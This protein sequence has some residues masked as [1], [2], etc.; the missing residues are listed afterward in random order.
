LADAA[1]QRLFIADT[2]HN[3][4]VVADMQSGEVLNIVGAGEFGLRDGDFRSAAFAHPQGMALSED[5]QTLYVA[6]TENHALRRVDL[7]L[8]TVATLV[9]TGSQSSEYPP[10]GGQAPNVALNSPWDLALDG[11]QLYIAMAG[12]HQ[13]WV[14]DLS[15]GMLGPFAGNAREGTQDGPLAEAELAQPSGL[16]LD[17][18]G[19]LYFTDPEA[20]TVRWATTDPLNGQ[21]STLVGSGA[22]LFDFGDV[23][24]VGHEARLQ[25]ALGIV[26]YQGALYVV[27][28]YNSKIKRV[29]PQTQEIRTMLGG[30]HGWRDGKDPLFY[31]PGGIDAAD[32][33]LYV[34]DTNNHAVRVIDLA[35]QETNTL[36]LKDIE[37]FMPAADDVNFGGNV[38]RINP[39]A[40]APGEGKLVLDVQLPEGYKVNQLAPSSIEWQVEDGIVELPPDADL[41]AAALHFPLEWDVT[42]DAGAGDLTGDLTIFYCEAEKQSVCLI[43]QVR[44]EA[45]LEVGQG[46]NQVLKL[47]YRIE[48]PDLGN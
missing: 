7:K 11:Q 9:G 17:G 25:H 22:S 35:T 28:T 20:S 44:L 26:Y 19:R 24:G 46:D 43:E 37:R 23:D 21:V 33:R 6:D 32:G 38:V 48:L 31:E 12:T 8:E 5:G 10:R 45:P 3:R 29:D 42:F 36:V 34:A 15:S 47:Q 14:M 40:L 1:R 27:D 13:V 16:S 2:D 18:K 41:H 4:I 30:E 39:V